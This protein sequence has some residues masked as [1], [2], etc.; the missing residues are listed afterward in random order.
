MEYRIDGVKAELPN[1]WT[2]IRAE[3]TPNV[4]LFPKGSE[5]LPRKKKKQIKKDF[6]K[7]EFR[8]KKIQ[9]MFSNSHYI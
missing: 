7:Y 9:D 5:K 3:Y 2:E 8:M 4:G 1:E 6:L